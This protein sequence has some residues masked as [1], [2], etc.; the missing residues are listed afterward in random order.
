MVYKSQTIYSRRT[1]NIKWLR[2]LF[3]T[4]YGDHKTQ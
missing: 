1:S 3:M 4:N 2:I